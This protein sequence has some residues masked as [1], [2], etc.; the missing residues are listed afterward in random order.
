MSNDLTRGNRHLRFSILVWRKHL[1]EL[2]L[3]A[4][5]VVVIALGVL[6]VGLCLL[7]E[8][9]SGWLADLWNGLT[10][11][12]ARRR[13]RE[14]EARR[15][16]GERQQRQR[17]RQRERQQAEARERK[18]FCTENSEVFAGIADLLS[19][20]REPALEVMSAAGAIEGRDIEMDPKTLVWTDVG[21]ILASFSHVGT[22]LGDAFIKKLWSE[23]T[24]EI[25]PPDLDGEP[26]L[27]VIKNRG[28]KQLGMILFLAEYD[29]QQGTTLSAKA[30]STYLSIVSAV[31]NH[32]EGSVAAKIVAGKYIELLRPYIGEHKSNR[33]SLCG[34]CDR[35]FE[36]IGLSL[37]ASLGDVRQKRRAWAEVLH[38]D[39]LGSKSERARDAAEQ[40]LKTINSAC[41]HILRC[42]V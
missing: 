19:T 1:P 7:Y 20:C 37:D 8:I 2:L 9:V 13:E 39:Q 38:P 18:R 33:A 41:D 40:Q 36:L 27:S 5:V 4:L 16:E 25:K 30:A 24:R 21:F 26:P 29:K 11:E 14:Q 15:E 34:I 42:R 3:F 23:L 6:F 10:G 17:E 28:V 31:S 32:C 22:S 35:A 12:T